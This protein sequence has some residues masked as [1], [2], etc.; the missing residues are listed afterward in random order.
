MLNATELRER[1]DS[2]QQTPKRRLPLKSMC[3]KPAR[4][5]KKPNNAVHW[6]DP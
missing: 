4:V 6:K 3:K 1:R 5:A 2:S